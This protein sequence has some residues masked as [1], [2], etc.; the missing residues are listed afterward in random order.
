MTMRP[1]L[2]ILA[3]VLAA[4]PAL[5]ADASD[6]AEPFQKAIAYAQKRCVKVYGGAAGR[7]H[8]YATGLVVSA[9]GLILTA[10][11]IY[12][13]EERVRVILPDGSRHNA[14]VLRRSE[15]LQAALLKIDASTPDYFTLP[16][17]TPVAQG[18]WVLAVSNAFN[19]AGPEE[20]LSVNLGIVSLMADL[21]ARHRTQDVPYEGEILLIDAITSN[22]GAPGGALVTADGRLAGMLGKLFQ[23]TSTNT[24]INYAVPAPLLRAFVMASEEPIGA[25]P[26]TSGATAGKPPA[27][28]YL[29]VGLFTLSGK[30][31]PA[32]VDRVAPGSPAATAGL[33][34]DDLVLAVGSTVVR[35]CKE[36]EEAFDALVPGRP[37]R[38]LVKRGREVLTLTVTPTSK[39]GQP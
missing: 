2:L 25:G 23:S 14:E 16:D 33:R 34:A 3:L 26:A 13:S 1:A 15:P 17:E 8:G 35:S 5:A 39:E 9:D 27:K 20:P 11:G 7:E 12:L 24:R 31:A 10:Q 4:A 32:Y 30:S 21:E 19:V 22:P 28:P 29:G 6:V 37:A 38:L 18:D 36:C